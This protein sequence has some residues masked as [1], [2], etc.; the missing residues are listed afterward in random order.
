MNKK[1]YQK[2]TMQI[3]Q[4]QQQS[5]IL[6]GSPVENVGVQNYTYEDLGEE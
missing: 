5:H 1:T 2:P 6:V 4:L 3:V